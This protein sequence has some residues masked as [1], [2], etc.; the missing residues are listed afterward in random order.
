MPGL[1]EIQA[2][3]PASIVAYSQ[4]L[5]RT[6]DNYIVQLG[7]LSGSLAAPTIEPIVTPTPDAPTIIT[8]P[9]P[10]MQDIVWIAPGM[11]TS[12]TGSL[13]VDALMPEPFDD[14][15]PA[16]V[17]PSAPVENIGAIPDA[18][19]VE[20][21]FDYPTLDF[22]LPAAPS[23]L[24]ISVS[25]F[26]GLDL[27][28]APSDTV[29][30]LNL[31][32]PDVREYTPGEGYASSLLTRLK[33][34]LED[35]I[36]NGGT[37]L[38]SDVEQ[39]IWDRGRERE[40]RQLANSLD[41][42][43][44]LE[45]MGFNLP[46]GIYVDARLKLTREA[47]AAMVG[48]SREVM[49]KQAELE[50]ANIL[51][52]LELSVGLEGKLMDYTNSV[53]QRIFE[54]CKY[55]TEAGL[56]LYNAKVKAY[57][58]YLNAYRTKIDIYKAQIDG[59]LAK[60]Q[61]YKTEI[62]AERAKAEVNTALVQQFQ[63]QIQAALANV[64]VYKAQ[65]D[66][67]RTKADIEK[68]KV[69]VFG[70]QVKAYSTKVNA[71]TANVEAFRARIQAE[72]SKQEA[73]KSRVSVYSAQ[74]DAAAK[75]VDAK[76]AEFKGNLEAKQ[77]EWEAYKAQVGA[78]AERNKSIAVMN[79]A[80]AEAY[81]A[82]VSGLSAYNETLTKQWAAAVT[83]AEKTNELQINV[84]KMNADLYMTVRSLAAEAAKVGAQVSAQ[85]GAAAMNAVNFN[86]SISSSG[87]VSTSFVESNTNATST[88]TSTSTS[89]VESTSSSDSTSTSTNTNYNYSV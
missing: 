13:S 27:P 49:I 48:H 25:R 39:A 45:G 61:A 7:R 58:A 88:S 64:D 41:E 63:A 4:Q 47:D 72:V 22:S 75:V 50:Q 36:A 23:L 89:T 79:Q 68:T 46:T 21:T 73:Y 54:S 40:Y 26:T 51:K 3:E 44:R 87:S 69:E 18:P 29:P 76:V 1:Y 57:E 8:T 77:I 78:E 84:A 10:D 86:Q 6:A 12:F 16:L 17:I 20:L 55:A 15:P 9:L 81:K 74:V 59:E 30:T 82:E 24:S 52:A 31:I 65:V 19:G 70:E 2:V 35:R 37:G 60:V 62:E 53:E 33:A 5:A 42:L 14:D 67:I 28:A 38:N 85:L 11:P 71:Y 80:K 34:T 43:E 32:A 56:A 83:I 66:I